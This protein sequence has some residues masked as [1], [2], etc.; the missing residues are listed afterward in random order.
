MSIFKSQAARL[1]R[2]KF[3]DN[4]DLLAEEIIAIFESDQPIDITSP[5]NITQNGNQPPIT[6]N[7][8]TDGVATGP[9][10]VFKLVGPIVPNVPLP[11]GTEPL[12][13]PPPS[14]GGGGNAYAGVVLNG[15]G[16]TYTCTVTGSDGI[17]N[18]VAVTMPA[19][20]ADAE[21]AVGTPLLVLKIGATYLG[22]P[23]VFYPDA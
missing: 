21:L 8:H 19:F 11:P 6:L 13:P 1:R 17:P 5:L 3:G 23:S 22:Y 20:S 7:M 4:A 2:A 12:S 10:I 14:T 9:P 18:V 15:S 16:A